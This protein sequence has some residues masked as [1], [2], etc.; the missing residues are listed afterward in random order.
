MTCGARRNRDNI[1]IISRREHEERLERLVC[2]VGLL[3]FSKWL[4]NKQTPDSPLLFAQNDYFFISLFD[5]HAPIAEIQKQ[6]QRK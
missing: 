3:H 6:R 1:G 5:I 4:N 2:M